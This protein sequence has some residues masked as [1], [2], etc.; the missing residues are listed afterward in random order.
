MLD[1]EKLFRNNRDWSRRQ[2]EADPEFF[3]RLSAIQSP[4]L[5]WIGCSD[6]RVPANQILGLAPGEVF[7]HRNV[8][9]LVIHTDLNCLSVIQYAVEVLQVEHIFLCGHYGC[10]GV[11]AAYGHRQLGLI[12][13]WLRNIKDTYAR[14]RGELE[15]LAD[16]DPRMDRLCE[17]NVLTQV[18]SVCHT[19]LV[20][21][22]WVRGQPLA[23]HGFIYRLQDGLLHDL[24]V[25]ITG[26]GQLQDIYRM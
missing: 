15:K 3:N 24:A 20:Q 1:L 17:L 13:H 7:V 25:R 21:N 9:N 4:K 8:A 5:L 18:E 10:G 22:A 12:D 2:I 26:P 11:R 6:S 16:G 19:T 23:V 14:H